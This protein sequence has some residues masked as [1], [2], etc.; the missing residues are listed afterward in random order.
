LSIISLPQ[1]VFYLFKEK[2]KLLNLENL[3]LYSE[4]K[5]LILYID[6]SFYLNLI[7]P[8]LLKNISHYFN[9]SD[10]KYYIIKFILCIILPSSYSEYRRISKFFYNLECFS[11][12]TNEA[13]I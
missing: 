3:K 9:N 6:R 8:F 11:R 2:T 1:E 7:R 4:I 5:D 13:A 12:D 10:N